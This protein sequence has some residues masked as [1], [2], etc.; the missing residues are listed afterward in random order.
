[1]P[2]DTISGNSL[3]NWTNQTFSGK[4]VRIITLNNTPN[5]WG[6]LTVT[7]S[8]GMTATSDYFAIPPST[9]YNPPT[10]LQW[11]PIPSPSLISGPDCPESS[12]GNTTCIPNPSF[13]W[14][15]VISSTLYD[16]QN[17]PIKDTAIVFSIDNNP[18]IPQNC[19][20]IVQMAVN[21]GSN[22][23][24][25]TTLMQSNVTPPVCPQSVTM[26]G[27]AGKLLSPT[28]LISGIS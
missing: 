2:L 28:I 27:Q 16:L 19:F 24:A 18:N 22:G 25:S 8:I 21:T 11:D 13:H 4:T 15:R 17:N 12:P 5:Y 10:S 3:T 23:K 6:A 1:M 20:S 7:D 14:S 9:Q 26:H